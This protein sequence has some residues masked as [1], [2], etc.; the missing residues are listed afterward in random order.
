M[1]KAMQ[2]KMKAAKADNRRMDATCRKT[3][4]I[5][6]TMGVRWGYEDN[7]GSP[8]MINY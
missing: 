3:L 8:F 7:P 4:T 5:M 2:W 1:S 6:G